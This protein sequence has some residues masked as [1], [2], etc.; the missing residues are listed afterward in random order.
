MSGDF[1][2]WD[3]TPPPE[4]HNVFPAPEKHFM[5]RTPY[6]GCLRLAIVLLIIVVTLYFLAWKWI[7]H[8]ISK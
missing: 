2:D 1:Q 5:E 3:P 4:S 6:G 7:A 8:W